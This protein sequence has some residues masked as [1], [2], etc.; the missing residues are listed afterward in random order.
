MNEDRWEMLARWLTL[1][2]LIMVPMACIVVMVLGIL[3]GLEFL[4]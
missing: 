3:L 4:Q 2:W 1:I